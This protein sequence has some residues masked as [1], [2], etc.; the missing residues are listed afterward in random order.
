MATKRTQTIGEL[1][2]AVLQ[3]VVED[4]SEKYLDYRAG[5]DDAG[6]TEEE[7][8][9]LLDVVKLEEAGELQEARI[10]LFRTMSDDQLLKMYRDIKQSI[11]EGDGLN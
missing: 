5:D 9:T 11:G 6:L 3:G 10:S 4:I 2:R 7:I 1:A 8:R